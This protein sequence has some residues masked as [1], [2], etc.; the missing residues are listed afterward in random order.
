MWE[1]NLLKEG[2]KN[3]ESF[4]K[5]VFQAAAATIGRITLTAFKAE[6]NCFDK[7]QVRWILWAACQAGLAPWQIIKANW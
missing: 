4:T 3:A 7:A 2:K 1:T 5:Y 6:V